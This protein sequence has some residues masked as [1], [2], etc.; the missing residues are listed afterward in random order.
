MNST[1]SSLREFDRLADRI[2]LHRQARANAVAVVEGPTDERVAREVLPAVVDYFVAGSRAGVLEAVADACRVHGL[3]QVV[4]LVDRDFDDVVISAIAEG[5]PIV[6]YDGADLEAMIF[7]SPALDRLLG[8]MASPDK[9][10]AFGGVAAVRSKVMDLI[11][12]VSILRT[13]NATERWYL[14]FD[15]VDLGDRIKVQS[16]AFQLAGYIDALV[17]ASDDVPVNRATIAGAIPDVPTPT[18]P[19]SAQ[20]LFRGRDAVSVLGV[21]LRRAI[22]GCQKPQ[23]ESEYLA[24]VLRLSVRRPDLEPTPWFERAS[25]MLELGA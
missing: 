14:C 3:A 7:H 2:R 24:G 17:R 12:H 10:E 11:G 4:G 8:E 9:L 18:C 21:L 6:A 5:L 15:K 23:V 16:L 19:D 1:G 13:L 25:S 22:G 20:V